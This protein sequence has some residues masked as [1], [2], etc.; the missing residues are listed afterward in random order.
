MKAATIVKTL[1]TIAFKTVDFV[2]LMQDR[3]TIELSSLILSRLQTSLV[4]TPLD[5]IQLEQNTR[6]LNSGSRNNQPCVE[7]I[8]LF[9]PPFFTDAQWLVL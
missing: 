4:L 1:T 8:K 6:N 7:V 3:F 2:L 9:F 5:V